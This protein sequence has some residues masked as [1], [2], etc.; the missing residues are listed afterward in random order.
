VVLW[1]AV[2]VYQY[3]LHTDKRVNLIVNYKHNNKKQ[4]AQIFDY[5][6]KQEILKKANKFFNQFTSD[7]LRMDFTKYHNVDDFESYK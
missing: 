7:E 1:V 3:R 5:N 4:K 6:N 2:G